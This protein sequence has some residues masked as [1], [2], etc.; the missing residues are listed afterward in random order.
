[1]RLGQIGPKL[2]SSST[3]NVPLR[4][5]LLARVAVHVKKRAAVGET[6]ICESV[7]GIDLDRTSEHLPSVLE[8]GP[9]PLVNEL[10]PAQIVFVRLDIHGAVALDRFLFTFA[11]NHSQ[12]VEDRLRYL[13]LNREH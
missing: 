13:V 6:C 8:T 4:E 11:Q 5:I 10:S 3:R 1:M 12:R 7:V 2:Q 9:A